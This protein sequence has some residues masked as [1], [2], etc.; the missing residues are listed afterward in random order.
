M[1]KPVTVFAEQSEYFGCIPLYTFRGIGQSASN[2]VG[3]KGGGG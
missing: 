3:D 1:R 2:V